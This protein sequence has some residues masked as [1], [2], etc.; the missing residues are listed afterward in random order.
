M[1]KVWSRPRGTWCVLGTE[2]GADGAPCNNVG[3]YCHSSSSRGSE[4]DEAGEA[5][6]VH[7]G[8]LRHRKRSGGQ[9]GNRAGKDMFLIINRQPAKK[10]ELLLREIRIGQLPVCGSR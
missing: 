6:R 10:K 5:A 3:R 2:T 4:S 7:S 8:S 9:A 1:P